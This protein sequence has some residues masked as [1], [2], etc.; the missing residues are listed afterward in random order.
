M[1]RA[2]KPTKKVIPPQKSAERAS[3]VRSDRPFAWV[4]LAAASFSCTATTQAEL[5]ADWT[6]GIPPLHTE[7][8]SFKD[9][10]GNTVVLRGVAL[11]DPLDL[12]NR[13]ENMDVARLLTELTDD[14]QGFYTRVVRVTVFPRIWQADP[15]AYFKD[16]LEPAVRHATEH[17]LYAIIDWHEIADV[18]TVIQETTE[19]WKVMAPK[20]ADHT[21]VLYELFNEP[22]NFD[23]PSWA[24]W[25]EQAQPW[26]DQIRSVAPDRVLLVGGPSWDQQI[27]GAST[28]P[29]VGENIAYVGH[30]YPAAAGT[31]LTES[32]PIAQAAAV[33]PVI[34]TEWGFREGNG[35]PTQGTQTSF[36]KP[37]K[38]FVE[39]HGLSWTAWCADDVWAPVMFDSSWNL[40]VGEGEMGGFARDWL[41][42]RKDEN[43]P[44]RP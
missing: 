31:L 13:G 6:G 15:D 35:F 26:I 38:A 18:A 20:F 22:M 27:G 28:D 4:V 34:I 30:I 10:R 25:K 40:L 9:P 23:N 11:A 19:F 1:K 12:D 3:A 16:H 33:R 24:A 29:F 21:N 2:P 7:G 42:E 43:Q 5:P 41:A 17:G 14:G 36:G 8:Q 32:G 44:M 37:F 39:S